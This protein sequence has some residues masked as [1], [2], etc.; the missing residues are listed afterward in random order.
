LNKNQQSFQIADIYIL[1]TE[2]YVA[3][4]IQ[5]NRIQLNGPG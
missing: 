4:Q 5:K 1:P 3:K 2:K